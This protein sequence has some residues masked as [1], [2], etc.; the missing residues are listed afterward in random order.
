MLKKKKFKIM[1][2]SLLLLLTLI[3]S[4]CD[5]ENQGLVENGFISG[6][7]NI[8]YLNSTQDLQYNSVYQKSAHNTYQRKE[9]MLDTLVYHRVRSI[10]YD[11]H[12]GKE[13]TGWDPVPG[14]WYIYHI[15]GVD[16]AT[17]VHRLSDGLNE[18]KAF[19]NAFPAHEVVTVW[20]DIKD[21]FR[22]N[23]FE[24][25]DLDSMLVNILGRENIFKP[26][27]VL[28]TAPGTDTLQE[29]ITTSGWPALN[30][31][32]G[33]FIFVLTDQGLNEYA[34]GDSEKVAFVAPKIDESTNLD[35]T[36]DY[37]IF[38]NMNAS[39]GTSAAKE[40]YEKG[41]VSRAYNMNE[42]R[43]EDAVNNY[44]HHLGTDMVNLH[45]DQYT[46]THNNNGWPFSIINDA[47]L[48][49]YELDRE[50]YIEENS[51]I[52]V[53]ITGSTGSWYDWD[54]DLWGKDDDFSFH[55]NKTANA[56]T[57]RSYSAMIATPNSHVED[58][59]KG[60]LIARNKISGSNNG[61]ASAYF[62]VCRPADNE[63]LRVQ[64]RKETG[65]STT[66]VEKNIVP[67]D[68][69]DQESLTYVKLEISNNSTCAA[70]YGS[71][72]G[73]NWVLINSKCGFDTLEYEG[74]GVSSHGGGPV[75]FLFANV[76]YTENANSTIMDAGDLENNLSIGSR[77]VL[78]TIFDGYFE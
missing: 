58:W 7:N 75:K 49:D 18:L 66:A 51:V 14:N 64:Y 13:C 63:K 65:D 27:D 34:T 31:L 6:T 74:I 32:K 8:N 21:G 62:G 68:T 59:A 46:I 55:F 61:E 23:G 78:S 4:S 19:H 53:Q 22:E 77:T 2:V 41:F 52:G 56:N 69:I 9:S 20:M 1:E 39:N 35:T 72:D 54:D 40:V 47:N 43:W 10:E 28:D 30:D 24:P 73:E 33:K 76:E 45:S 42:A 70:G 15:C 11:L 48:S 71:Q 38:F 50:N 36:P 16:A 25:A 3:L 44:V 37:Q 29:A 5:A 17:T 26:Q 67:D 60:C 12:I 57:D